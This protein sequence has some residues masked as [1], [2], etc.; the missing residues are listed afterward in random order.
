MTVLLVQREGEVRRSL[1]A[2]LA[3]WGH[4]V[5]VAETAEAAAAAAGP[6]RLVILD[7]QLPGDTLAEACRSLRSAAFDGPSY[8]LALVGPDVHEAEAAL[9]AGADD[10]LLAPWQP[11]LLQARLRVGTRVIEMESRLA[12]RARELEQALRSLQESEERYALAARAANDGLWDWRLDTNKVYF[13]PRW[14]GMLGYGED[15]LSD[16]PEEWFQRVHPA[17]LE[18]VKK[19]L[20]DHLNGITTTFE[21]EHRL[22]HRDGTYRWT[23]ARGLLV[24]GPD[25][26]ALRVVGSHTDI[27][28]HKA[29]DELSQHFASHDPLTGLRN[30]S[31]FL[32]RVHYSLGRRKR[33]KNYLFAVLCLDLDGFKAINETRGHHFGDLVLKA[34]A[35]RLTECVR[36]VDALGRFGDDEFVVLA[37]DLA[38]VSDALRVAQRINQTVARPFNIEGHEVFLSVSIGIAL[39]TSSYQHPEDLLRDADTALLRARASGRSRCEVFDRAIHAQTTK[40]L[41]M[42]TD[43]HAAVEHKQFVLRYQPIV[44]LKTGR[45]VSFEALVRWNHPTRGI[46]SPAEFIPVAEETGLILP[47]GQ[48]VLTEACRQVAA[49]NRRR[50]SESPLAVHVN[51]SGKQFAEADLCDR[52]NGVLEESGV[53][54]RWL[55]LE[56]TESVLME[57]SQLTEE[58]LHELKA[59]DLDLH[60]DDFGTGYSSLSYLHTFPIDVLK[61]DR[62]FIMRIGRDEDSHTIVQTI[63][64]L[65][66]DLRMEV[67]AEGVER[68]PQLPLLRELQCEYGQGYLFGEPMDAEAAEA[69]WKSEP[70]W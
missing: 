19:A 2:L 66:R 62:S 49:W 11:E 70:V 67:V 29:A 8:I 39:S 7:R 23:M 54:P 25:G 20:A 57:D 31:S 52:L 48:W 15:E 63:V 43:L 51:L 14:K 42:E 18:A 69:L 28:D 50:E 13:A 24:R 58:K 21:S 46:V 37:D 44:S 32:E 55:K 12:E 40:R 9:T 30:R 65:A 6:P 4:V 5:T 22:R 41:Q 59:L 68:P 35:G 34:V 33:R 36:T 38:D 56:L 26:Q 61:I 27:T 10:C 17:D 47:V 60:I 53:D 1:S 64:G 16:S 3:E 45:L